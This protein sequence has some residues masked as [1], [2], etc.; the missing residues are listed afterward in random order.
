MARERRGR[1]GVFF[2]LSTLT[3]PCVSASLRENQ[4]AE[5]AEHIYPVNPVILSKKGS[6][7]LGL[8]RLVSVNL[9][10]KAEAAILSAILLLGAVVRLLY[11]S[12]IRQN[13]DFRHPALDAAYHDYWARGLATGDWVPPP[14]MEAPRVH[15]HPFYRP[16]AYPYFLSL[17]YRVFG[18]GYL[19]PRVVQM[20]IGLGNILLVYLCGR[21]WFGKT[22][23]LLAALL[24]ATYWIF[25]YYEG[26]LVGEPLSVTLGLVSLLLLTS[27][28][29]D[30]RRA[31][32]SGA[33]LG[34]L[35]LLR[36]NVLLFVPVAAAWFY[37]VNRHR[38][39]GI[40]RWA[41]FSAGLILGTALAVAP[42][43]IRNLV[44]SG[45]W[46]PI[47]TNVGIS[48]RVA[49][50]ELSDGTSHHIPEFGDVG[51]PFDYSRIVRRL[52]RDLGRPLTQKQAAD[53]LVDRSL[54][55][56]LENPGR[57]LWL[58]G[59]KALLFWG[60][61]EIRNLKEVHYARRHSP[62][63][64]AL[65]L[66]VGKL[67]CPLLQRIFPF[68]GGYLFSFP[69]L[70]ALAVVG[71]ILLLKTGG[72]GS[73]SVT[74]EGRSAGVLAALYVF[75]YFISMLPFAAA[76]RYRVPVI[77]FLILLGSFALVR[78]GG[79]LRRGEWSR[80]WGRVILL[81]A[82]LAIFSI[83]WSGY[84]PSP[85]KWHFDLALAYTDAGEW[86]EAEREYRETVRISPDHYRAYNNLGNIALGRGRFGEAESYYLEALR[87]EPR[88]PEVHTNLG[89]ILLRRGELEKAIERYRRALDLRPDQVEAHNNLGLAL[90][91]LGKLEEAVASYRE[92]LSYRPS[93]V[94]SL[95]G[96]AEILWLTGHFDEARRHL[97]AAARLAPDDAQVRQLIEI[98]R[99]Q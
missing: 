68:I 66:P 29:M 81:I 31:I 48:L 80:F 93:N 76:A 95:A 35:A 70:S 41:G 90:S 60:P 75:A 71:F 58:T 63:L 34:V 57:F 61:V 1:G 6:E 94:P 22:A 36:P 69:L 17:V 16:P 83:N 23:G 64:G 19:W 33:A 10:K 47:S 72:E 42:V 27:E 30:W 97:E 2:S 87:I 79:Y 14:G 54:R 40:G 91:R 18:A 15:L 37:R 62:V 86:D 5:A 12:E 3:Y 24:A 52:E 49:N 9:T 99:E 98:F 11:L 92:A 78:L 85:E 46:V 67:P 82:L 7:G 77:P 96:L 59:R 89:N 73:S 43:A 38:G 21:R 50:N 13:P 32:P 25:I 26:E 39:S 55:F 4:G 20:A 53:Y 84:R 74:D 28:R 44:V 88:L 56:I 65:S 8:L 45:E 51:S